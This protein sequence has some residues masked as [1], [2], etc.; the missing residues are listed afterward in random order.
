MNTS[1]AGS[2][3]VPMSELTCAFL[4]LRDLVLSQWMQRVTAE[5]PSAAT[6]GEPLLIDTLPVLYENIAQALTAGAP[7]PFATSGTNLGTAHGRER[8]NMTDYGAS[9]LIHELQIFRDVLFSIAASK[10]L[11]LSKHDGEVIGHSIEEATRES[12][13]GFDEV[14]KELSEAF[15][16]GLSHDLRNPLNVASVSAQLIL[17]KSTDDKI[18]ALAQRICAKIAETDA[19]IQTLLDA[20]VLKAKARMKLHIVPLDI[21]P[22]I[23]E[24]C[25]DMFLGEQVVRVKGEPISGYWCKMSMQRA[26]QNLLSNAQK[27]G[28]SS[29]PITVQTSRVDDR[30]IVSVHNEGPT[31]PTNELPQLFGSFFRIEDVNVKGWGLGLPFVQNVVESHGGSVIVDSAKE[32]GT[33][34]TISLPIDARPYVN[35]TL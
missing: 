30:M 27:Y 9:E 1:D 23:E 20:A 19:M 10:N 2:E 8:A 22:L 35:R 16:A 28:D 15:I 26:L 34:F 3:D 18:T 4:D 13:K 12:I 32:R 33:T 6:V 21:M 25:A 11:P 7:R 29:K 17:Q 14:N 31:I 24:V 5:I